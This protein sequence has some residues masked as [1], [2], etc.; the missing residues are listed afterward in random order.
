M[1]SRLCRL[2]LVPAIATAALLGGQ[3]VK[4]E[5]VSV[6]FSFNAEGKT[7]SAGTYLVQA[8]LNGTLLTLCPV[9]GGK[10]VLFTLEPGDPSPTDQRV[11]L[12]FRTSGDQHL[13]ESIVYR[14]KVTARVS[15][16]HGKTRYADRDHTAQPPAGQ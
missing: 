7:F 5:T 8:T 15:D 2:L 16:S 14:G 10:T 4:A 13:L 12:R 6:P 11:V 3:S 1:R 9:A